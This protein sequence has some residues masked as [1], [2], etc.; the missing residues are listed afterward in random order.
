[1]PRTFEAWV[2]L[3]FRRWHQFIY[4]TAVVFALV[5]LGTMLWPPF[6]QS[7]AKILVQDDRASLPA[8][9]AIEA[10]Q[11][12]LQGTASSSPAEQD[13]NSEMELLTSAYLIQRTV[14]GLTP[15]RKSL[16]ER[17]VEFI[18]KGMNLPT[19]L[20]TLL[21]NGPVPDPQHLWVEK[22]GRHLDCSLIKRSN[23]IEVTFG[24]RD[25]KWS[26][27]FLTRLLDHYLQLRGEISHDPQAERFFMHQAELLRATLVQSQNN[28]RALEVQTGV[29]DFDEQQKAIVDQLAGFQ[30][31]YRQSQSELAGTV[32]QINYLNQEIQ[33]YPERINTEAKTVQNLALQTLKPQVLAL[34]AERAELLSRYRPESRRIQSIDAKLQ[35]AQAL[36]LPEKTRDVQEVSTSIN[37]VWQTLSS[38]LAQAKVNAA[39]LTASQTALAQQI[40]LYQQQL[41]DVGDNGVEIE[42][43]RQQVDT[44]KEIYLSYLR[45][46]EEARAAEALN[47]NKI[48]DVNIAEPPTLP[49]EPSFPKM[50]INLVAGLLLAWA[51]AFAIVYQAEIRD[52]RI[53]SPEM[54]SQV[55]GVPTI[56]VVALA[57]KE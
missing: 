42:Q 14:A 9:P 17:V 38:T 44:D 41:K 8:S 48:L 43:L 32:E 34:E 51:I 10:A 40:A 27:D 22:L 3:L 49:V 7:S 47:L 2:E 36:L 23:I 20:Y 6:Y 52:P 31:K 53:Y 11:Q 16:A 55:S 18:S 1:L 45:K 30:A 4:W 33:K 26:H 25:A 21:H 37:P 24:S 12:T 19:R 39:S 50:S 57:A 56:A 28:L 13:M 15:A 54:V 35:A 46:G 29:T 5:V